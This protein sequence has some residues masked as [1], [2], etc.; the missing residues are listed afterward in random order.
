MYLNTVSQV[1]AR[2]HVTLQVRRGHLFFSDQ[3]PVGVTILPAAVRCHPGSPSEGG[4]ARGRS[5]M[6]S[7]KSERGGCNDL[8]ADEVILYVKK[9]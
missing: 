9:S 6:E 3:E 7:C 2:S 4:Q 8:S 1:K 5:G